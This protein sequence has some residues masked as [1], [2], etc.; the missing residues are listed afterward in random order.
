M[1]TA[2]ANADLALN[3]QFWSLVVAIATFVLGT[4]VSIILHTLGRKLDFRS[5]MRRWDD[6]RATTGKLLAEV[7][8][9]RAGDE[10]VLINARRYE[11][12]YDG[13]NSTNRLGDLQARAEIY[14]LRHNGIEFW[15]GV[16]ASWF[17]DQ[18]RRTLRET[19]TRAPN[20]LV[21][22]F[23]PFEYVEHIILSGDEYKGAPIFYVRFR[24]PGKMPYQLY[25][26]HETASAPIG[27]TGRR[28]HAMIRELGEKRVGRFRAWVRFWLNRPRRYLQERRI[29]AGSSWHP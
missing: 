5:R 6:L 28:Y 16:E 18:G 10:V 11:R 19:D 4:V 2:A 13:G 23:V 26:F 21:A 20:V 3:L 24:G 27:L 17:D 12:D 25:T 22:G 14:D 9:G 1:L 15:C 7:R 29:E 8:A